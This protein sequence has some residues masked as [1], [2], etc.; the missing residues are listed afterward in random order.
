LLSVASS[1]KYLTGAR[2]FLHELFPDFNSNRANPFMQATI[3]GSIKVCTDPICRK[4]PIHI[5]YLLSFVDAANQSHNYDDLLFATIMSCCFYGCHHSGKLVLKSKR[6]VDWQKIIEQ[7]SL[8]FSPG[9]AGYC[10][11]YHK[12]DPIYCST[13]ILFSSQDTTNPVSLLKEFICAQDSIHGTCR[14]LFLCKDGSHPTRAWFDAKLFS[15]IN[16]T[17]GGHPRIS[18]HGTQSLVFQ[19]MED[20]HL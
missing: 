18:Y 11:P 15:F 8:H 9:Y 19:S 5:N 2:Y 16:R 13:D 17:F 14:A 6:D 4:Q 1:P 7:S 12:S 10:L 20:L 3:C